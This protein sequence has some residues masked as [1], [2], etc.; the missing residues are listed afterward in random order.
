MLMPSCG[1]LRN[2]IERSFIHEMKSMNKFHSAIRDEHT[3]V[4]LRM[5]FFKQHIYLVV[6]LS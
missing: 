5:N 2:F 1:Q 4:Q 3:V 6:D